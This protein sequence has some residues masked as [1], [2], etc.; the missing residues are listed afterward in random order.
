NH[1]F[2]QRRVEIGKSDR[3]VS[4]LRID[5]NVAISSWRP[6][7]VT[8]ISQRS[9]A[10]NIEPISIVLLVR[11][12]RVFKS[13]LGDQLSRF[14][15]LDKPKEVTGRRIRSTKCHSSSPGRGARHP[16]AVSPD[17]ADR[18]VGGRFTRRKKICGRHTSR[19]EDL[20]LYVVEI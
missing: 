13:R 17:V 20:A 5:A 3:D 16:R 8:V 19:F 11:E 7:R 2:R 14:E 6:S 12:C 4:E 18:V 15:C 1:S 9:I 10:L